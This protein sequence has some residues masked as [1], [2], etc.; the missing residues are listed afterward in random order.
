V[1]TGGTSGIEIE[2]ILQRQ[3]QN[4]FEQ[5]ESPAQDDDE[6]INQVPLNTDDLYER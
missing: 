6:E 5:Y 4:E 2:A 3:K 1:T